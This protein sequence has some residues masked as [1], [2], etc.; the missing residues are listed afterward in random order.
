MVLKQDYEKSEVFYSIDQS[1]IES[2]QEF[3]VEK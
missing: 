3:I 2:K 1:L